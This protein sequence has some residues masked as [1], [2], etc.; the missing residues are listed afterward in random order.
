MNEMLEKKCRELVGRFNEDFFQRERSNELSFCFLVYLYAYIYAKREKHT[1]FY[2]GLKL[3]FRDQKSDDKLKKIM[4]YL[5]SEVLSRSLL[6]SEESLRNTIVNSKKLSSFLPIIYDTFNGIDE[7]N[8]RG[9]EKDIFKYV[10]HIFITDKYY[11]NNTESTPR[12]VT[13]LIS[14]IANLSYQR[15]IADIASKSGN[16]LLESVNRIE[17]KRTYIHGINNNLETA[18]LIKIL[19]NLGG[20]TNHE[21]LTGRYLSADD[22]NKGSFDAVVTNPPF[23]LRYNKKHLNNELF[24]YGIPPESSADLL[25][26]VH[27]INFLKNE[28]VACVVLPLSTLSKIGHEEKIRKGILETGVVDAVIQLPNTIFSNT[29]VA[30]AVIVIRKSK[31]SESVLMVDAERLMHEESKKSENQI[32]EHIHG[33]L[34]NPEG[35]KYSKRTSIVEIMD[36]GSDWTPSRYVYDDY[37]YP[38]DLKNGK[39]E[40]EKLWIEL[41][42]VQENLKLFG[43]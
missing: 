9:Q 2:S 7:K 26:L 18:V 22:Q 35:C 24:K 4:D 41:S 30:A 37:C 10:L 25:F 20:Y 19:L 21:I 3:L 31:M 32:V 29:K 14:K 43:Y 28:G 39:Q 15:S 27:S 5:E 34:L 6:V 11:T 38:K 13:D 1:K 12:I 33:A 17:N 42:E 8:F 40:I 23:S 16:M 36:S